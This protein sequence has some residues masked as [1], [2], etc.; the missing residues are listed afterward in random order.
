VSKEEHARALAAVKEKDE[1]IA[2]LQAQQQHARQEQ[3]QQQEQQAARIR[4]LEGSVVEKDAIIAALRE[5]VAANEVKWQKA[6]VFE[7]QDRMRH[8][9][10]IDELWAALEVAHGSVKLHSKP[11]PC[12]IS[13]PV[14]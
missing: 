10:V 14:F 4:E 11:L 12:A 5:Q 6:I 1:Q 3:L 7:E 2:L 9:Q 8:C 13:P